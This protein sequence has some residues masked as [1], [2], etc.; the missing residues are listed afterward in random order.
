MSAL[1]LQMYEDNAAL[2]KMIING[3]DISEFFQDYQKVHTATLT[4]PNDRTPQFNAFSHIFLS[5]Q[6][7]V[8]KTDRDSLKEKFNNTVNSCIDCHRISCPGPIPRI[9]KLYIK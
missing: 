1:M 7:I 2:K 6:K 4:D 9:K 8:F 3:E 5:K